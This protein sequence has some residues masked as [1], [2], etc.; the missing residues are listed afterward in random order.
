MWSA[1]EHAVDQEV[2]LLHVPAAWAHLQNAH[3]QAAAAAAVRSAERLAVTQEVLLL[4]VPAA[5]THLQQK[6]KQKKR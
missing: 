6:F 4:H 2:L 5:R 3:D 1:G